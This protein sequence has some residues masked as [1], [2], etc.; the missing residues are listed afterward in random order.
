MGTRC[1]VRTALCPHAW[2]S[3]EAAFARGGGSA[4][5][6]PSRRGA[7][8]I[9]LAGLSMGVSARSWGPAGLRA[10]GQPAAP[11]LA[12]QLAPLPWRAPRCLS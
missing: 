5:T 4:G 9:S 1:F 12:P 10:V 7:A 2:L 3:A 6:R 8:R 11:L